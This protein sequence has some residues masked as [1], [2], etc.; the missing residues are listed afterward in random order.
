MTLNERFWI[1]VFA[2]DDTIK[3]AKVIKIRHEAERT[4]T[5]QAAETHLNAL[6]SKID[7]SVYTSTTYEK[8]VQHT[9]NFITT[10]DIIFATIILLLIL[11]I[12]YVRKV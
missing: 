3:P 9:Q 4:D 1:E 10:K 5:T 11:A 12:V 8:N 6:Q 2:P 7:S